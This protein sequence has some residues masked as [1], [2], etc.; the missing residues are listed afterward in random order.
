[1]GV[2]TDEMSSLLKNIAS[3]RDEEEDKAMAEINCFSI[4]STA[5]GD[6]SCLEELAIDARQ[7]VLDMRHGFQKTLMGVSSYAEVDKATFGLLKHL[8]L[9]RGFNRFSAMGTILHQETGKRNLSFDS[10]ITVVQDGFLSKIARPTK[11]SWPKASHSIVIADNPIPA[12]LNNFY[13]EIEVRKSDNTNFA[14]HNLSG[15]FV[16]LWVGNA[17]SIEAG[18]KEI[19]ADVADSV[20]YHPGNGKSIV[21]G[22]VRPDL[23]FEGVPDLK[24]DLATVQSIVIGCGWDLVNH[25]VFFT[26]D[27][28]RINSKAGERRDSDNPHKLS[29]TSVE[30]FVYPAVR[31]LGN[32]GLKA[33]IMF[34]NNSSK[35]LYKFPPKIGVQKR[36]LAEGIQIFKQWLEYKTSVTNGLPNG[37]EGSENEVSKLLIKE[38]CKSARKNIV[39]AK[40]CI[41]ARRV[42]LE[43]RQILAQHSV[44]VLMLLAQRYN[45]HNR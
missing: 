6:I 38:Q 28:S 31:F 27:G 15:F 37:V 21:S 45:L 26:L 43:L 16:G 22:K 39:D 17:T 14:L 40:A 2:Q 18:T 10:P 8:F 7:Q 20:W 29:P 34:G 24:K 33:K 44:S 25:S 42:A 23:C 1:M 4:L 13:F 30:G 9:P 19:S 32:S 41:N 11:A 3:L 5:A 35:F 36:D 12:Y